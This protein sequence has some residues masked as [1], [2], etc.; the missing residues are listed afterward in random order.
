MLVASRD[1]SKFCY[2][3]SS[4]PECNGTAVLTYGPVKFDALLKKEI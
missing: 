3:K 2:M 4:D 1:Y